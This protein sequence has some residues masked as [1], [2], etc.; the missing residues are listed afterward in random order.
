MLALGLQRKSIEDV[1]VR[2]VPLDDRFHSFNTLEQR[3]LSLPVNQA[4]ALLV[5]I[6]RKISKRLVEIQKAVVS[7]SVPDLRNAKTS[8]LLPTASTSRLEDAGAAAAGPG[9]KPVEEWQPSVSA[10][11]EKELEEAGGQVDSE[12]RERQKALL[13]SLDLRK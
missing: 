6:V 3:E 10:S 4:L 9:K 5:K 8:G 2:L 1:E 13:D 11:I 7:A 12:L